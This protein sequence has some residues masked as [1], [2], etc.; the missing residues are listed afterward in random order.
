M[1]RIFAIIA[2]AA[3]SACMFAVSTVSRV[4]SAA[5]ELVPT[6]ATADAFRFATD[7]PRSIFETRRAGLA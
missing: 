1:A 2:V 4:F 5:L 7:H 6:F 3:L